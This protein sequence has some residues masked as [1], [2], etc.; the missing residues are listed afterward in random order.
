[1]SKNRD[2]ELAVIGCLM[3]DPGT[4][5]ETMGLVRE[6]DFQNGTLRSIF[7]ACRELFLSGEPV[8][9]VTVINRL[10]EEARPDYKA[11]IAQAVETMPSARGYADYARIVRREGQKSRASV[12]AGELLLALGD[13]SGL[14]TCQALAVRACEALSTTESGKTFSAGECLTRFFAGKQRPKAYI[15]TG[16][17]RLDRNTY[18]DRGDYIIIGGRPSAGKTALTLQLMLHM[19]RRYRVAYFSLETNAEKLT[20]RMVASFARVPLGSIKGGDPDWEAIAGSADAFCRLGFSVVEASGWTVPQIK[21]EAVKLGAEILFIDYLGLIRSEGRSRY[22]KITNTS[23]D[24]HV[25]AQQTGMT[26]F[27]LSQLRRGDGGEPG[28]ADLRESG[29]LEQDADVILLLQAMKD[30]EGENPETPDRRL[31]IAKNK[32]GMTG[33]IRLR[34]D[35]PVQRFC[36]V[37]DDRA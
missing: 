21:A 18:I 37:S 13:G 5:P 29:Q 4:A 10:P 23:V 19:A 16:L 27:A 1:M 15:P 9:P 35:G 24:L 31:I 36:E 11:I 17:S 12:L 34:F 8:D 3:S 25:L 28:M 33:A 32:E 14:E 22:E 30:G 2:A 26:V 7:R 20:D 6:E